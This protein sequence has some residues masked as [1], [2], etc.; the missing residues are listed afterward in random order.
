MITRNCC[1]LLG[2]IFIALIGQ[3]VDLVRADPQNI[4]SFLVAIEKETPQDVQ[5]AL[6]QRLSIYVLEEEWFIAETDKEGLNILKSKGI[7]YHLLD[8]DPWILP[9]YLVFAREKEFLNKLRKEEILWLKGQTLLVKINERRALELKGDGFEIARVP[10]TPLSLKPKQACEITPAQTKE[11]L[12]TNVWELIDS[13]SMDSIASYIKRLEA[14]CTRYAYTDSC[15]AAASYLYQKFNALEFD[16]VA[17]DYF[18]HEGYTLKNVV[19]TKLG[20]LNPDHIFIICG[21]YDSHAFPDPWNIAPGADD[22]ASG[23][24]CVLEAARILSNYQFTNTIKFICFSAEELG[25]IGSEHYARRADSMGLNIMGVLNFDMIAYQDDSRLDLHVL[26]DWNSRPLAYLMEEIA[27]DYTS[28]EV[29][30]QV[31]HQ[32]YG[33]DQYYFQQYGYPAILAIEK[34][35]T[36]WNPHYHSPSDLFSSLSMPFCL[37]VVKTGVVS[38]AVLANPYVSYPPP[39]PVLWY[40]GDRGVATLVWDDSAEQTPD[41]MDNR[42]DFR[43]YRVYRSAFTTKDWVKIA[44]FDSSQYWGHY[45]HS[46]VDT[47]ALLG[48]PYFYAVTAYDGGRPFYNPPLLPVESDKD[49]FLKDNEGNPLP[50]YIRA[51]RVADDDLS[52]VTVAPNP[53]LGTAYWGE[54]IQ[55]MHLPG[56]CRILIYTVNGELIKELIHNDGTGDE[57]WDLYAVGGKQIASGLYIYKVETRGG[58]YKIGKFVVL[59]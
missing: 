7:S 59:R 43:G 39:S 32:V 34:A 27:K 38:L 6:G 25:L 14:F 4:P 52:S 40:S 9:Y 50:L 1:F 28:L 57:S 11:I 8:E 37:E 47:T 35:A 49:N 46:F 5:K 55:F 24:A 41:P 16:S 48:V 17:F 56:S 22:N 13:I 33:S 53:Y 51:K 18:T 23:T 54:K 2:L 10:R 15:E 3:G 21:H 58:K 42:L 36:E 45:P 20:V 19:A 44:E 12:N 26:T 29:D 31:R 30:V